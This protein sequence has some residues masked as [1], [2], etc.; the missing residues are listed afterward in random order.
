MQLPLV[1]RVRGGGRRRLEVPQLQLG[2]DVAEPA[3]A[4]AR[5]ALRIGEVG[6][7]AIELVVAELVAAG[8]D[9]IGQALPPHQ[10]EDAV[11]RP[12]GALVDR[13]NLEVG[14]GVTAAGQPRD[15]AH[16]GDVE[17]RH[18]LVPQRKSR[19]QEGLQLLGSGQ[20][21]DRG[22]GCGLVGGVEWL[23]LRPLARPRRRSEEDRH[24]VVG[25]GLRI[26]AHDDFPRCPLGATGD[27][28]RS[29]AR[30]LW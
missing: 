5:P 25:S 16:P 26:E 18:R 10:H 13:R 17:R 15:V 27:A 19:R 23:V 12:L 20:E 6:D 14:H 2:E 8:E 1:E 29:R 4:G 21:V 7:L 22:H 9:G 3:Q 28:L 30:P 24:A 11:H